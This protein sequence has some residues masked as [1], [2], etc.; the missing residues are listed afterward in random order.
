M[1]VPEKTRL[2]LIL[3]GETL[4][5]NL[6]KSLKKHKFINTC[7]QVLPYVCWNCSR[8]NTFR[9]FRIEKKQVKSWLQMVMN[10]TFFGIFCCRCNGANTRKVFQR[11]AFKFFLIFCIVF[12]PL[13]S[14]RKKLIFAKNAKFY[15]HLYLDF[16]CKQ[17]KKKV[18]N[19]LK[20]L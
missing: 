9:P 12:Q 14:K 17:C 16:S 19:H 2:V 8:G 1:T 11:L 13:P 18:R 15:Q 5:Q 3:F 7:S 10:L 6:V 20:H 4:F